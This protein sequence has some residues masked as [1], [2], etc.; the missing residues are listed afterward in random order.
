MTHCPDCGEPVPEHKS[1]CSWWNTKITIVDDYIAN[2]IDAYRK[3]CPSVTV[4]EIL[5]ALERIRHKLT[6]G[7]IEYT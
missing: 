3:L 7:L 5:E 6:E 1:T 4:M 2:G